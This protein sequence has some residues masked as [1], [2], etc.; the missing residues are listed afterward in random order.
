MFRETKTKTKT[1]HFNENVKAHDGK[2]KNSDDCCS[3]KKFIALSPTDFSN[4]PAAEAKE[5]QAH[6]IMSDNLKKLRKIEREDERIIFARSIVNDIQHG[7][8]LARVLY[9]IPEDFR[10]DYACELNDKISSASELIDVITHLPLLNCNTYIKKHHHLITDGSDLKSLLTRIPKDDIINV[11]AQ[12]TEKIRHQCGTL[13]RMEEEENTKLTDV[14][15][16]QHIENRYKH[17]V[18]NG[19]HL[20]SILIQLPDENTRLEAAMTFKDKIQNGDQLAA[21][22]KHLQPEMRFH[23]INR[24]NN[25]I[26]Q[27]GDQLIEI[28]KLIPLGNSHRLT[29]ASIFKD[30]IQHD[31]QLNKILLELPEADQTKFATHFEDYKASIKTKSILKSS[32]ETT[33]NKDDI[34]TGV[35]LANYLA[36]NK[37]EDRFEIATQF[38]YAIETA[39]QLAAILHRL[40]E[41]KR[42][43]YLNDKKHFIKTGRELAQLLEPTP[44]DDRLQIAIEL[45]H[46]ITDG[47]QLAKVLHQLPEDDRPD[48][49]RIKHYIIKGEYQSETVDK[50][51]WEPSTADHLKNIFEHRIKNGH[52][53][54]KLLAQIPDDKTQLEFAT[55]LKHKI[56]N[57]TQLAEVLN[58]LNKSDRCDYAINL[59]SIIESNNKLR[60]VNSTI[61]DYKKNEFKE[62]VIAINSKTRAANNYT[63]FS[64]KPKQLTKNS[65][66]NTRGRLNV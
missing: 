1:I 56:Q 59:F 8:H 27:N 2:Q 9:E 5:E 17:R 57:G 55:Q 48:F 18:S 47:F 63:L 14:P 36:Q 11:A 35:E 4:D 65:Q 25:P 52:E 62:R 29:L 37:M 43:T 54:A 15:A 46:V 53:L 26:I 34:K 64:N 33:V 51:L 60:L 20:M 58:R 30:R 16:T 40:P 49:S 23:F 24:I 12:F 32:S 31:E 28:I 45:E 61:P 22:L 42:L 19:L 3:N 44:K 21:V 13:M 10:F 50:E 39:H 7:H 66:P 38:A 6:K 41:D